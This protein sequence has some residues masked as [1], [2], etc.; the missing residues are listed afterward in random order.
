[1]NATSFN[2]VEF[3]F[4]R[5]C[6]T[7]WPN[8][9]N[10]LCGADLCCKDQKSRR[11][12]RPNFRSNYPLSLPKRWLE[13]RTLVKKCWTMLHQMFDGNQTSLNIIQHLATWYNMVAKRV[14][15]VALNNVERCW[16]AML[17]SFGQG[18]IQK[19]QK[20]LRHRTIRSSKRTTSLSILDL[21]LTENSRSTI[22][23]GSH[24]NVY[25]LALMSNTI[26]RELT[27]TKN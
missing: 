13:T 14:L 25:I 2:I 4:V 19:A 18:L 6:C 27:Y 22:V 7:V 1:M 9:C 21:N 3:N 12:M 5:W 24:N 11:I 26:A 17:P 16:I 20:S 10:M 15:H 8:E 23:H